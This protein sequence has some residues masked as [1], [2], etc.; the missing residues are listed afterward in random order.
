MITNGR[1]RCETVKA[2][3]DGRH[4]IFVTTGFTDSGDVC[5]VFVDFAKAGSD[6]KD[7][8]AALGIVLS[9]ALQ[10][11][12]PINDLS[13][14]LA[15]FREKSIPWTLANAMS[16]QWMPLPAPPEVER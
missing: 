8:M 4:S 13:A 10:H 12:V 9:V 5:E 14:P 1:R 7:L 2:K 3:V 15:S 6:S 11:G 16:P